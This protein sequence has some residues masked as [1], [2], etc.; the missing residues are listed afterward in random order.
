MCLINVNDKNSK[1]IF[2]LMQVALLAFFL[3]ALP[4]RHYPNFHPDLIDGVRGF[5]LGVVIGL[6][7]LLGW[8]KRQQ[9][10]Q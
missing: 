6:L 7:A 10:A 8:R 3:L 4:A 1:A 2:M 5:F 9:M